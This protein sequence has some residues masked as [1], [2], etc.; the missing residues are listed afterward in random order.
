MNLKKKKI[1]KIKFQFNIYLFLN[2]Q[3]NTKI[4]LT[5]EKS[6]NVCANENSFHVQK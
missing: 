3:V 1:H 5:L 4:D 6:N 2:I